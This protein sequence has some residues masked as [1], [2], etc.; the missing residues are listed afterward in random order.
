MHFHELASLKQFQFDDQII[1]QLDSWL[2]SRRVAVQKYLSP[3]QFSAHTGVK[4]D[5]AVYL[6][7]LCVQPAI[8]ILKPRYILNAADVTAA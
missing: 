7:A 1:S 8:A 3:L 4:K 6:F 5:T 2:M